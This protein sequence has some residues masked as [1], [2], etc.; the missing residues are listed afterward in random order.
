MITGRHG[1]RGWA[2]DVGVLWTRAPGLKI[3]DGV[4]GVGPETPSPAVLIGTGA[5]CGSKARLWDPWSDA[6]VGR[7]CGTQGRDGHPGWVCSERL[8]GWRAKAS[9][10]AARWASSTSTQPEGENLARC[11]H[12]SSGG[13]GGR[14]QRRRLAHSRHVLRSSR[15]SFKQSSALLLLLRGTPRRPR[16]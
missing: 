1:V 14:R 9:E 5:L 15:R 7:D 2:R 6:H 12:I 13:G 16:G 10:A 11:V 3:E 4:E 8:R